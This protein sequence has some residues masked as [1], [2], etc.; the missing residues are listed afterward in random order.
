MRSIGGTS[1]RHSGELKAWS[2]EW[3]LRRWWKECDLTQ[4]KF[5]ETW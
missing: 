4:L 2:K 1:V 5:I 3:V